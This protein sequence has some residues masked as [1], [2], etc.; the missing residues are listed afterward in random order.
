MARSARSR[1]RVTPGK[2]RYPA[3]DFDES[4]ASGIMGGYGSGQRFGP[5]APLVEDTLELTIG[6]VRRSGALEAG[7]V[8]TWTWKR[9]QWETGNITTVGQGDALR[10]VYRVTPVGGTARGVDTSVEVVDAPCNFGGHRQWFVC[11]RCGQ[12][13]GAMFVG[14]TV[15]CRVCHGLVYR[16]TREKS[17]DAD[18]SRLRKIEAQLGIGPLETPRRKPKGMRNAE[19]NRQRRRWFDTMERI[20]AWMPPMLDRARGKV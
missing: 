9:G 16:S 6:P 12:R 5:T 17:E 11:P 18:I 1:L 3:R 13:R 19:W 8:K 14:V 2:G 20:C 4:Q 10:F 15:A 7:A